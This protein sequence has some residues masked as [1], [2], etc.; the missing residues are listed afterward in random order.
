MAE[1]YYFAKIGKGNQL[2][3]Y[4]L[5]DLPDNVVLRKDYDHIKSEVGHNAIPIYFC[6]DIGEDDKDRD[7]FTASCEKRKNKGEKNGR[8]TKNKQQIENFFDAGDKPGFTCILMIVDGHVILAEPN[9]KV[10][11]MESACLEKFRNA[12]SRN[13]KKVDKVSKNKNLSIRK[14]VKLLPIHG[15][16]RWNIKDVP[17]VLASIAVNRHY[18]SGTFRQIKNNGN[19]KAIEKLMNSKIRQEDYVD[20]VNVFECLGSNELETLIAKLFEEKGCF[21]PAYRGGNMQGVDLFI[22]NNQSKEIDVAG[23]SIPAQKKMSLQIK[24]AGETLEPPN[25]VDYLINLAPKNGSVRFNASWLAG[26]LK[27]SP[28]TSE[29]LKLSL[30]WLPPGYIDKNLGLNC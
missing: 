26:A 19:I 11:F 30:D 10:E 1:K 24:L 3:P 9:G 23:I 22:H 28:K 12:E 14:W 29:W 27:E 8:N 17:T 4:Y 21:V 18:S 7:S 15:I 16:K 2:A 13:S 5:F 25:G 20:P 6:N